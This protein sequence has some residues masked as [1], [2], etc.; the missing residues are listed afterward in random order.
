MKLVYGSVEKMSI[1]QTNILFSADIVLQMFAE[2]VLMNQQ[3]FLINFVSSPE[4]AWGIS[5]SL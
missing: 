2:G 3:K 4:N 1:K 5:L